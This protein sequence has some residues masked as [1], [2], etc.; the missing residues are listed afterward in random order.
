MIAI[1]TFLRTKRVRHLYRYRAGG[2]KNSWRW[3][4]RQRERRSGRPGAWF[5]DRPEAN[6][7]RVGLWGHAI[8]L[9][10]TDRR[11][12]A[13]VAQVP[14]MDGYATGLRRAAPE[15]AADLEAGS[16]P[17]TAHS[18]GANRPRPMGRSRSPARPVEGVDQAIGVR[19]EPV[20]LLRERAAPPGEGVV[21]RDEVRAPGVDLMPKICELGVEAADL[22]VHRLEPRAGAVEPGL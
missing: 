20:V 6:E 17:M 7:N 3:R 22:R 5:R 9:G 19:D 11:L 12:K 14:T 13:A 15:A 2:P 8:V 4:Q 1:G 10:T 18:S 21:L 16:P